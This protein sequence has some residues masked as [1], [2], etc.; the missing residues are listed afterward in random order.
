MRGDN[1]DI[2][3]YNTE[4]NNAK[5][6]KKRSDSY[7]IN[8]FS[9]AKGKKKAENNKK[10]A[11]SKTKKKKVLKVL[12]SVFLIG[13]ISLSVVAGAFMLYVFTAVDGTMEEDLDDLKLNFTTTIYYMDDNDEWQEYQRLHGEFN[14]IWVPY[15]PVA[16]K[17]KKEGYEGIPENLVNAFVAIEDKRFY[18]HDG[19]DWKRTFSA[20]ANLFLHFYS[21]NQGGSTITQQL[22]KNLTG[23]SAQKPSRKI[24]EI[25]RSRYLESHYSKDTIVECYL[26]TIAMGNGTYGVEVAANYYFDKSVK[27]LTLLECASLA[28]ITKAPSLYA[29]DEN[30]EENKERRDIVLSEMKNQGYITEKEYKENVGKDVTVVASK[31]AL[32]E[33]DVNN[34]F[35]DALITQVTNDIAEKYGYDET[36]AAKLFY[37][38]GYKIYSTVKPSVQQSVDEVFTNS[39]AY[40]LE[41]GDGQKLQGG[42]SVMDYS[43]HVVGLSGGIGEKTV[44]LAFNR[45]TDAARQPGST[46]KPI[47][48]YAPAIES[49]LITYSSIVDDTN[50]SYG[51]WTPV[52][53]YRSYWGKITVKYALERS[54][55]TIPVWLVNEMGP[56]KSYDFLTKTL[57][58][59]H[60]TSEDINL[61]PLGMGGT[62]GGIT[63]MESAAAFAIFGN[64][65][66]Y[67]EPKLYYSV[68]DQHDEIVISNDE[69]QPVTAIGEDTA[70]VMNKLLQNVV[71]GSYGTGGGAGGYVPGMR[72]YAKTGTSN[73]S[74]DLWFVGGTPYYIASCW[75]GYDNQTSIRDQGIALK[76]WGAV[77]SRVH[78]GLPSKDF[79]VSSYATERYYCTES[80]KLATDACPN[81]EKGWYTKNTSSIECDIHKGQVLPPVGS[82]AEKQFLEEKAKKQQEAEEAKKKAEEEKKKAEEEKE[83]EQGSSDP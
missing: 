45:A 22:V 9:T 75:C 76:M 35:V 10:K 2:F 59:K 77:M 42:I 27:D 52:N 33:E 38:S 41:S 70:T 16:A 40:A 61:A 20:F 47:A 55:N 53:W 25:M 4:K 7:D 80:G 49:G 44:N 6:G 56:S 63:P 60:L 54:V 19:V 34:Y 51:G 15:D 18:S 66:K 79:E 5:S 13:V 58:L 37:S 48:A 30:P 65:G 8:S 28:A 68:K 62:N 17:E 12:L 3:S 78:S 21:S 1:E 14:R 24:R 43:G 50:K 36:H 26:N 83:N 23:D 67:Y 64:G 81:T 29:P 72:V 32:K 31:E 73:N 11:N 57:G 74:N 69:H 39:D 46:M 82:E 71:Y